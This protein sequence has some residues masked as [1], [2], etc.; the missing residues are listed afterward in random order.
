MRCDGEALMT[1]L[2]VPAV[3]I[4]IASIVR[5]ATLFSSHRTMD[6][7]ASPLCSTSA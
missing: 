2:M 4:L 7:M 1:A 6:L 3:E 5:L